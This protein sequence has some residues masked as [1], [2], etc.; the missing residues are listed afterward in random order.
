MKGHELLFSILFLFLFL[1]LATSTYL[2]DCVC[3]G[4]TLTFDDDEY[5][6][7][8]INFK[9][10]PEGRT[11]FVSCTNTHGDDS[12][13]V[14]VYGSNNTCSDQ[15]INNSRLTSCYANYWGVG[16]PV[17]AYV[18]VVASTFKAEVLCYD[19][20]TFNE[21]ELS[22]TFCVCPGQYASYCSDLIPGYSKS[23]FLDNMCIINFEK[24]DI[25]N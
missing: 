13:T 22:C 3:I 19:Y 17:T 24:Y 18:E 14:Q 12:Y 15:Y 9:L 1:I 6:N 21:C 8:T 23:N 16:S 7:A 25:P 5:Y 4:S 10:G 2:E 20:S 11:G